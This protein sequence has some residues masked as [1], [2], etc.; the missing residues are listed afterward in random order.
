M[1]PRSYNVIT[2][3]RNY[4]TTLAAHY[5]AP[6]HPSEQPQ[7]QDTELQ[8]TLLSYAAPNCATLYPSE[9]PCTLLS[10]YA[11]SELHRTLLTYAEP[12]GDTLYP[13]ELKLHPPELQCTPCAEAAPF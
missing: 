7:G 4:V 10:Y 11:H 6:K 3:F 1:K 5:W 9:L 12:Y 13:T 2:R 8:H